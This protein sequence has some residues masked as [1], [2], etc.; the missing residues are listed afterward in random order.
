[1]REAA[2]A[3]PE[4]LRPRRAVAAVMARDAEDGSSMRVGLDE[5]LEA[6]LARDGLAR[7]GAIM[8]VDGDGRLRGIV[9]VDQVRRALQGA[10][11]ITM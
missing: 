9:T 8:A 3:I 5:P 1:V 2:E 6:A 4:G 7:L 10:A 11:P